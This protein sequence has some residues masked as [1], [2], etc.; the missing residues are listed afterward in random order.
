MNARHA[1]ACLLGGLVGCTAVGKDTGPSLAPQ[2][3]TA[4]EIAARP[5]LG[6]IAG[7]SGLEGV[8]TIVLAGDPAR[9]GTYTIELLVPAH[10]RIEAHEHS[11]DR[12]AVVMSGAWNFGYGSVAEDA[13]TSSLG[14]G[15]FYTE[16]RDM[17][18]FA[19]TGEEPATVIITGSGPTDTRYMT[20]PDG[21]AAVQ[22]KRP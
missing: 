2:R 1:I 12:T 15:S 9:A 19:Y 14:P 3:I 20:A 17:P 5:A 7:T 10:T 21:G 8:R 11:D 6:A 18:H 22:R 4:S 13:E 16:P